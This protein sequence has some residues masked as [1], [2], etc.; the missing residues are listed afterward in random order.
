MSF[1][2]CHR[3]ATNRFSPVI[4]TPLAVGSAPQQLVRKG[5]PSSPGLS[6]KHNEGEINIPTVCSPSRGGGPLR[7]SS[8][9]SVPPTTSAIPHDTYGII[10]RIQGPAENS[11][12][13]DWDS[14]AQELQQDLSEGRVSM[15]EVLSRSAANAAR[16]EKNK[17]MRILS[18][19]DR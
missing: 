11:L 9:P 10:P 16:T 17:Y 8:L 18:Q 15:L 2:P 19:K 7:K 3:C 12:A 13:P 4:Q 14:E 5:L 6:W 1:A